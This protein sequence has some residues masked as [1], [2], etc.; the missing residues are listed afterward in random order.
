MGHRVPWGDASLAAL[1]VAQSLV[2]FVAIPISVSHPAWHAWMD[3][4]HLLFAA[5][6]AVLLTERPIVRLVLLACVVAASPVLSGHLGSLLGQDRQT[7]RELIAGTAFAFNL[8]VTAL[9]ASHTF[10][11][12]RVTVHRIQGAVL[13]YLN[14]AI[15][16]SIAYSLLE[17]HSPG[18][19]TQANGA[20][21]KSPP[22]VQVAELSY[23][24]LATITTAGY[25]DLVPVHPLAR[26]LAN[27]EALFGQLFPAIF[28]A[29]VV[30]LNLAHSLS[31]EQWDAK[32]REDADGA[33]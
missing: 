5:M 8:M 27:L 2:T 26:S 18:A 32:E 25:G 20:L 11:R 3:V 24:S 4:G 14:V 16:F 7:R 28:L 1:L 22:Q 33:P 31:A 29:R 19:I 6:C 12:G 17:A 21:L 30:A 9:A 10:G 13:V 23:F 15:L